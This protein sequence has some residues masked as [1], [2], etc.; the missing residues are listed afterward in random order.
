MTREAAPQGNSSQDRR[1]KHGC[2][3]AS[4]A[5]TSVVLGNLDILERL[6]G[7]KEDF[8]MGGPLTGIPAKKP[9][10]EDC[11]DPSALIRDGRTATLRRRKSVNVGT[12][13][14]GMIYELLRK[15]DL[16][17]R[18]NVIFP[19]MYARYKDIPR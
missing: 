14:G 7:I 18:V 11:S 6:T 10:P 15:K 1:P 13:I 2:D 8:S 9:I 12:E 17:G 4:C 5:I 19:E 3:G 16:L